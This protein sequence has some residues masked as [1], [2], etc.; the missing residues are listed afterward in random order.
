MKPPSPAAFYTLRQLRILADWRLPTAG[1]TTQISDVLWTGGDRKK[2][3]LP[4]CFFNPHKKQ[5]GAR[6][7]HINSSAFL[8][9]GQRSQVRDGW[10]QDRILKPAGADVNITNADDQLAV[11]VVLIQTEVRRLR[12]AM[13]H[14]VHFSPGPGQTAAAP[15]DL[16][17]PHPVSIIPPPS[18]SLS[19]TPP[20][21]L[22]R[23]CRSELAAPLL[24][25]LPP[26]SE[27][28]FSSRGADD[29]QPCCTICSA[30]RGP[31]EGGG[32]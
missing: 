28:L 21:S 23:P 9:A 29:E 8:S 5:T 16:Q 20:E 32:L 3:T 19:R 2:K 27:F 12:G 17:P 10:K 22:L 1:Q 11:V 18:L 24:Q 26:P 14:R 15:L 6:R 25:F 31:R 4:H 7:V 13:N 30:G